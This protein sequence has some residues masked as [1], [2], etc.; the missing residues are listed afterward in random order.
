MIKY[1]TPEDTTV[2]SEKD[3][4]NR[5]DKIFKTLYDENPKYWENGLNRSLFK[6]LGDKIY[7]LSDKDQDYG[8]IGFQRYRMSKDNQLGTGISVGI[9][10]QYRGKGL[11]KKMLID[12]IQKEID[13]NEGNLLWSCHKD[14]KAS[15]ALCKSLMKEKDKILNNIILQY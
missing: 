15:Q 5:V 7:L 4:N 1:I 3:F 9:L 12:L 11:A 14:N 6:G 2:I 13:K 10:P 8:F